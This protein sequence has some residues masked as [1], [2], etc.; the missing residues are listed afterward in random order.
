MEYFETVYDLANQIE[1]D[2]IWHSFKN[3]YK[4]YGSN[5]TVCITVEN[6]NENPITIVF[7]LDSTHNN[8][9]FKCYNVF[10]FSFNKDTLFV[11]GKKIAVDIWLSI[12]KVD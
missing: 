12:Y 6:P 2:L 11:G 10:S 5:D 8:L 4:H 3:I 7:E 9:E 1:D